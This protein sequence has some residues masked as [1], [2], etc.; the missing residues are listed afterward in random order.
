MRTGEFPDGFVSIFL[1]N[2]STIEPDFEIKPEIRR[3]KKSL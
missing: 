2:L 3:T 1:E